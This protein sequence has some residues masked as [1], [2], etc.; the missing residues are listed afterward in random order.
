MKDILSDIIRS[1]RQEVARLKQM[2]PADQLRMQANSAQAA[3]PA[4]RSM[5]RSLE[6]SATGI[7]AEFKRRSPS[8]GW[9]HP[10]ANPALIAPAY[11]RAGAAALSILTDEPFFGG[12]LDDL[13]TVRPLVSL[14]ILRKDFIIDPYQ[15]LQARL[16]GAD[17]V[18]LIAACLS[19]D[20]CKQLAAEAHRLGLEVLLEIHTAAELTYITPDIDMV[21]VN[22]R[23]L[24]SFH[25]D[26]QNSFRL[27][28]ELRDAALQAG[29]PL[30]VSESGI[31]APETINQLRAAGFRGFL[32]GETFM[33]TPS[34]GD[35]LHRFIQQTTD[36]HGTE[37]VY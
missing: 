6:T 34:P 30:L 31:A 26:V 12:T 35:T 8:K 16:A 20:E 32:I 22:N 15:L 21:G 10:E 33:K 9:L 24:G 5:R 14:P 7:I 1:K 3:L 37:T 11:E 2:L 19:P 27:A 28:D 13:H 4:A 29:A 23:H 25:T 17:A 36:R 18:L